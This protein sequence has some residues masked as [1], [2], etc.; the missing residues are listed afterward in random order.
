M[1]NQL[2]VFE[3]LVQQVLIRHAALNEIDIAADFIEVLTMAGRQVIENANS[4]AAG[5][6][7]RSD[8]RTDETRTACD[9]RYS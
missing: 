9:Q 2:D 6:K 7:R 4:C 3:Y 1:K 5:G 8:V